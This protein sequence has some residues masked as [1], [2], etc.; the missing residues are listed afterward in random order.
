MRDFMHV[1]DVA[2]AFVAL[3]DSSVQGTINVAS[4]HATTIRDVVRTIAA[5]LER[6]DLLELGA[7]PTP[8]QEPP[9]LLADVRR[10]REEV[11]FSPRFTLDQGL[12]D[13]IAWW[14]AQRPT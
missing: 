3:L 7:R 2:G 11:R 14:R 6:P 13:T 5:K 8:P 12:T 4:G 9:L 1:A 10:L